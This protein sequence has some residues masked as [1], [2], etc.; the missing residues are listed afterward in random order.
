MQNEHSRLIASAAK[1]ALAPLG[2]VRKGRSRVWYADQRFWA[3][4]I[5]FQPSG[6]SKGS[7]LNVGARYFWGAS[8]GLGFSHRPV[9]FIPFQSA[10]Q[11]NPLIQ[12]MAGVA[13][14]EVIAMRE[15]F[16]TPSDILRDMLASPLR[17]GWP[18]YDAAIASWLAGEVDQSRALFQ[19]IAEWPTY[20]YDWE[21]RLKESSAALA[22]LLDRPQAFRS[23]ILDIIQ[24]QRT[25]IGLAEDH[26]CLDD[27]VDRTVAR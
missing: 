19:R 2:C 14:R 4:W 1:A 10:E 17:D 7:Y 3:I 6:W 16:R 23:A 15:R 13:A 27:V 8:R 20:G 18:V 25:R 12:T 24:R 9:D 26:G 11:F 21:Q 5:E 22:A